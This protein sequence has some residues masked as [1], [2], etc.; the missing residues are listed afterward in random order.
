MI[1]VPTK[2]ESLG[3]ELFSSIRGC[4]E[5]SQKKHYTTTSNLRKNELIGLRF[6]S[7]IVLHQSRERKKELLIV[8]RCRSC[9]DFCQ[10]PV[11]TD[12]EEGVALPIGGTSSKVLMYHV[13]YER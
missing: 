9:C 1:R 7:I 5:D 2:S 8:V 13:G 10:E 11:D 3:T 4:I 6:L 12:C